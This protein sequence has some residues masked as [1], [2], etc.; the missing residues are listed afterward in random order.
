MVLRTIWVFINLVL[1]IITVGPTII[2]LALFVK[3]QHV[4]TDII[5][6]WSRWNVKAAGMKVRFSGLEYF[7]NDKQYVIMGNHE[8]A[9]D[10]L[11]V[12][13]CVPLPF[14]IVAKAELRNFPVIGLAMARSLFPFVDRKNHKKAINSLNDTFKKMAEFNLSI[15]I[16][17]E[18]TRS[19]SGH[20]IPFK[21]G[22]FVLAIQQKLPILP[23]IICGAGNINPPGTLWIKDTEVSLNFLPIIETTG[24]DIKQRRDLMDKVFESMDSFQRSHCEIVGKK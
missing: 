1:S 5:R 6:F 12:L 24:Y 9:L 11:L 14:R 4:Y 19:I 16:Y 21:V 22:G 3:N 20:L 15:F 17:P 7:E 10:I 23:F 2:I 8:S 18:G 13:A